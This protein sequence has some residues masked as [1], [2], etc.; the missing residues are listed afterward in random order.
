MLH[1]DLFEKI[2]DKFDVIVFNHPFFADQPHDEITATMMD[3]GELLKRFLHEAKN[4]MKEKT[5]IIM[6]FFHFAGDTNNPALHAPEHG[7]KFTEKER[8]IVQTG[9]H[10]GSVSIYELTLE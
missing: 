3:D 9:L 4:H 6:P 7:Y 1:G 8:T 5:S 2:K 10:K